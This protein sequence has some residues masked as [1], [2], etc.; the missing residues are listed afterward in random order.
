MPG[1][2]GG[3]VGHQHAF[4]TYA[5]FRFVSFIAHVARHA[6]QIP[7]IRGKSLLALTCQIIAADGAIELEFFC[8]V[9]VLLQPRFYA[10]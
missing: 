9:E 8:S 5:G 7:A 1:F 10:T 4:R 6:E 3:M 2:A